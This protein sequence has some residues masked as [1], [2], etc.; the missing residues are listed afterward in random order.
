MPYLR[1]NGRDVL[2]FI[3]EGKLKWTQND[4]DSPDAGRTLDGM[5]HRGKVTSKVKIEAQC[6]PLSTTEAN[7]VIGAL[8]TEYLTVETD[9]D[10]LYGTTSYQ[11]YN[12]SRPATCYSVDK[13]TGVGKWTDL[14]F[15]L[16]ER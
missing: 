9:I 12:S 4:I 11:M 1:I 2:P 3:E 13:E 16:I 10:P 8:Q 6:W 14:G 15:N 7:F 5:M